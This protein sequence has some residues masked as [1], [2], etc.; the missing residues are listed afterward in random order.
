M[1]PWGVL[2]RTSILGVVGCSCRFCVDPLLEFGP[3]GGGD[4]SLG[5]TGHCGVFSPDTVALALLGALG[6]FDT[7]SD[8][9]AL[10]CCC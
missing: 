9:V 5:E 1:L 8:T 2:P 10:C 7:A 6:S 3:D 4:L